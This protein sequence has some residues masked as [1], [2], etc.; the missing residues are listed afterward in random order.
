MVTIVHCISNNNN[1]NPLVIYTTEGTKKIIIKCTS[2]FTD[3]DYWDDVS[4]CCWAV[5]TS[6]CS[7]GLPVG[8][9]PTWI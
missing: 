2:S 1:N 4:P 5:G 9:C 8:S 7:R 3:S 6:S